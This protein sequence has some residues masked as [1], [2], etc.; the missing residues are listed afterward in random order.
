MR[1][2]TRN[3]AVIINP[4]IVSKTLETTVNVEDCLSVAGG[5]AVERSVGVEIQYQD[6]NGE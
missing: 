4:R 2:T 3:M 1:N 6:I 5:Y